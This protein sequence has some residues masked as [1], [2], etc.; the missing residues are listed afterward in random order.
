MADTEFDG[1]TLSTCVC[2]WQDLRLRLVEWRDR[3]RETRYALQENEKKYAKEQELSHTEV[4]SFRDLYEE[5]KT[6]AENVCKT[7]F[8]SLIFSY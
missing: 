1:L 3:L 6:R 2:G 4:N 8:F 5:A 7:L